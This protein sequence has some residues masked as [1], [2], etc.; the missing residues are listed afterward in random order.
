MENSFSFVLMQKV[1]IIQT[2]FIGDVI[3]STALLESIQEVYPAAQLDILVRKGN[4]S[5]FDNHPFL[6]RVYVWDK[7]VAKYKG[8]YNILR[9]VRS[10]QYDVVINLQR[11]GTTGLFTVLSKAHKTIGFRKNPFSFL[12]N[13]AYPH[14]LKA[15]I[16]EVDRNQTLIQEWTNKPASKPKLYP[17]VLDLNAFGIEP[18]FVCFAPH[19]VWKTKQLPTEK[20]IN[21]AEH[22]DNE[23]SIVFLGAPSELEACEHLMSQIDRAGAMLNMCGQLSLLESAAMMQQSQMNYVNDSAPLHLCSA[24]DA[25]QTAFFCSTS[26]TFGFTPLSTVSIIA[27]ASPQPPCKPCGLHGKSACPKGHFDC[28]NID[29]LSL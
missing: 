11:F 2:S 17:K 8:L 25:P 28:G 1:L 7:K 23:V 16:H 20:W 10:V 3:L 27:E 29:V 21:L 5:L 14:E 26:P 24:V 9:Q 12:F 6:N 13:K 22:I 15:G 18:P 4:E 19:S